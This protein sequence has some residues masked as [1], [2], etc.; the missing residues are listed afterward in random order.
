MEISVV[1]PFRDSDQTLGR[2][3]DALLVQDD[4]GGPVEIVAVEHSLGGRSAESAIR[5][6]GVVMARAS[7]PGVYAARNHGVEVAR[8]SVIA[9][10]DPDCV[11]ARGW[12]RAIAAAIDDGAHVALGRRD[13]ARDSRLVSLLACYELAKDERILSSPRPELYYGYTNNM[14]ARRTLFEELGR[15][16]ELPRGGDTIFVR[17]VVD[18]HTCAAVR[19][20]PEM[21]IRHLELD[22]VGSYYVKTFLYGRHRRLNRP[23]ESAAPLSLRH[24]LEIL[25]SA[26]G[27]HGLSLASSAVLVSLLAGGLAAW[28][29]GQL[30]AIIAPGEDRRLRGRCHGV[31][32]RPP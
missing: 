1:V 28:Q 31:V 26:R 10:T 25:R 30:S 13:P 21:R 9:F 6:E 17:R 12:L 4:P 8:G 11:P 22:G 27:R 2:C 23:L 14:A 20:C 32:A 7:R 15:F 3:L 16:P 24:R 19:Y 5:R 18:R 29:L